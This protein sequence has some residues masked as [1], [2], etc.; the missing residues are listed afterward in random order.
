ME[1]RD[2]IKFAIAG[3]LVRIDREKELAARGNICAYQRLKKLRAQYTE[4][5]ELARSEEGLE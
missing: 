2:I 3:M 5:L 4:L 1:Q